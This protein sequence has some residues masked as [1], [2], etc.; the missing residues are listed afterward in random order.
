MTQIPFRVMTKY[1]KLLWFLEDDNPPDPNLLLF[2]ELQF[3]VS[4][5]TAPTIYSAV[6]SGTPTSHSKENSI[7][8]KHDLKDG[9]IEKLNAG[10]KALKSF[11]REE[12]YL[13]EK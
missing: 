6:T 10:L 9:R 11:I 5:S 7:H 8:N 4:N 1:L 2:Q 3:S 12:L 13:M